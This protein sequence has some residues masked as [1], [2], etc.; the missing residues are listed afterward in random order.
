MLSGA[1]ALR[2]AGGAFLPPAAAAAFKSAC[3]GPPFARF[4]V[5]KG[6]AVALLGKFLQDH[7]RQVSGVER[8]VQYCYPTS[9]AEIKQTQLA[10]ITIAITITCSALA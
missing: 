9:F 6:R 4:A 3:L 10:N 1:S 8:M 2:R 5:Q 7:Q